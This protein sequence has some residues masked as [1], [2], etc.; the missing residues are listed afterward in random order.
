MSGAYPLYLFGAGA[1]SAVLCGLLKRGRPL[2]ALLA[3][4]CAALG[5]LAGLTLGSAL[6]ELL[7]PVLLVC[8]ASMAALL[9]GKRDGA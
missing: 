3:A 4:V 6:G 9:C 8:A 5:V 1:L 7:S 2:W